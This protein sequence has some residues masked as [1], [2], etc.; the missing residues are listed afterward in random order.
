MMKWSQPSLSSKLSLFSAVLFS[1]LTSAGSAQVSGANATQT[2]ETK[3][4]LQNDIEKIIEQSGMSAKF[5]VYIEETTG[6]KKVFTDING[7]APFIPASNNKLPTTAVGL[8]ELGP[9]HRF[10][11]EVKHTGKINGSVLEGDLVI[12]GGGD[13]S[14]SGRFEKD[15][16]D[17]TAILRRWANM[18]SSAGISKVQGNI[19]GDD[20][21]FD[22]VYF[23]PAWWG[24][25]RGE[26]YFAE[27]SAL[28]FNDNCVDIEWSGENLLPGGYASL[29]LIPQTDYL[30]ISNQVVLTAPGRSSYR[31]YKRDAGSNDVI[32]TGTLN[33][34]SKKLDSASVN[35]GTLFFATVFKDVLKQNGIEVTGEVKNVR[36]AGKDIPASQLLISHKSPELKDIVKVINLVSQNLYAECLLKEIGKKLTGSGSFTSGTQAVADFYTK[37]NLF[38]DGMVTVDGSGLSGKN[39]LSGKLLVDTLRYMDD[40]KYRAEWRESLPQGGVRGSLARRYQNDAASKAVAKNI[41]GKTGSLN[42]VRSL[43][44]FV[45][46]PKGEELYYS[47]MINDLQRDN[48]S[49][50]VPLIDQIVVKI[51]Q[52]EK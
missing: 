44:G 4:A 27:V 48:A 33:A 10:I 24:P 23:H 13:P 31:E 18:L 35:D 32:V 14:I 41:F 7:K 50:A 22:D 6:T 43:S 37:N 45:V 15:K 26:Y 20:S 38:R 40:G 36:G 19:I 5:A 25:E 17:V 3:S 34:G 2:S 46:N 39:L 1:L 51:A 47:I 9:N 12:V 49:K 42:A 8:S 29:T 21:Y 28:S 30:K 16:R 11:T 52:F